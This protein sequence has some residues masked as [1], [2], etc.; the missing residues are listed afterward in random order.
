MPQQVLLRANAKPAFDDIPCGMVG[1]EDLAAGG[2]SSRSQRTWIGVP[3]GDWLRSSAMV[4]G[5]PEATTV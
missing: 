3:G 4:S 5:M 1:T 2:S